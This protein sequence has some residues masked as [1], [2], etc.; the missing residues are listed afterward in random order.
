MPASTAYQA[1][2]LEPNPVAGSALQ[3]A[4]PLGKWRYRVAGA[5]YVLQTKLR[6]GNNQATAQA[7]V[8]AAGTTLKP[9]KDAAADLGNPAILSD[10]QAIDS[11]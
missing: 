6:D 1:T 8:A 7:Y 11:L 3:T 9:V 5:L 10:F 2:Y 4:G